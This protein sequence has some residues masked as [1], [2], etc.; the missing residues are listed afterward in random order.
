[1][2]SPPTIFGLDKW[3]RDCFYIEQFGSALG[4]KEAGVDLVIM[5]AIKRQS[6]LPVSGLSIPLPCFF[7]SISTIKTNLSLC[8]YLKLLVA[9]GH[10][11]FLL[12]A[13]DFYHVAPSERRKVAVLLSRAIRANRIVLLDSGNYESY[14][15]EDKSWRYQQ[16][17]RVLRS[18][19]CPLALS[20]DNQNPPRFTKACISLVEKDVLRDKLKSSGAAILPI[21]HARSELLPEVIAGIAKRL[22]PILIAVPERELGDG[23]LRRAETVCRIRTALNSL[24]Q[25]YPLH[26]LGTGNPLSLLIY[27]LCGAD[28]FD[29]LEW[30]QTT[31][32]H[33]TA[34]LYHFQQ[35]ELFGDQTPFCAMSDIPYHQ[36][37]LAHNL[38]FY[39]NWMKTIQKAAEMGRLSNMTDRYFTK[40]FAARLRIV[41]SKATK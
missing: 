23:V 22:N 9:L 3:L 27:A 14:W 7:P 15:M 6:H 38:L 34:L 35:R 5:G 20:F 41:L 26:L 21:V 17:H 36:A 28:S 11:Q 37:T 30:C 32:D 39:R 29:G 16:Y 4:Y 13:Y 2:G 1:M 24:G 33:R 31:V 18:I 12:S 19:D 8:E 40:E 25:Y 10:P